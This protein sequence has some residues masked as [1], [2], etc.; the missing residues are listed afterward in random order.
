MPPSQ[1][2]SPTMV[3]QNLLFSRE[4]LE[5]IL[6][7]LTLHFDPRISKPSSPVNGF[8]QDLSLEELEAFAR[9]FL[10]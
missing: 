6:E 9:F 4:E 5:C 10:S 3:Y 2:R 7:G 1:V 8:F